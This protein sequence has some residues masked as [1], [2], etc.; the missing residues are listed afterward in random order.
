MGDPRYLLDTNTVSYLIKGQPSVVR[1][2]LRRAPAGS[3]CISAITEAELRHGVAK[4]PEA[5]RLPAAVHGFLGRVDILPWDSAAATAYAAF[6]VACEQAGK[7]LSTLDM[8]IAAHAIAAEAALITSDKA[9]Y[10]MADHLVLKDW[11]QPLK[12]SD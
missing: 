4:K 5:K 11:A 7:A 1:T 10:Q 2:H 8:L 6:H 3:V 9:F 12:S